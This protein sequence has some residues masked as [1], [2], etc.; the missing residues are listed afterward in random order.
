MN[1]HDECSLKCKEQDMA[2]DRPLMTGLFP[3]R[4]SAERG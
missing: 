3:D 2:A 4:D 1:T